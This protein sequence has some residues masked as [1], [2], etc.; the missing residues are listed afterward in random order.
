MS[1]FYCFVGVI[2]KNK[3]RYNYIQANGTLEKLVLAAREVYDVVQ[4]T[5]IKVNILLIFFP[6]KIEK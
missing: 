6:T 2:L 5:E 4:N 1:N 3:H